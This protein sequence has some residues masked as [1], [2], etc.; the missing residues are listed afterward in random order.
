[1]AHLRAIL[2]IGL[3]SWSYALDVVKDD[4]PS[5]QAFLRQKNLTERTFDTISLHL[6]D[7]TASR[8]GNASRFSANLKKLVTSPTYA[9]GNFHALATAQEKQRGLHPDVPWNSSVLSI[10]LGHDSS[11]ALSH[12][13]RVQCVLELERL[14]N[15]RYFD[16]QIASFEHNMGYVAS[17]LQALRQFRQHCAQHGLE[18][19]GPIRI[20]FG[21]I[22][23]GGQPR[24]DTRSIAQLV[25]S[26]FEVSEWCL[27]SPFRPLLG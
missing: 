24:G 26:E 21:V 20:D 18:R 27:G 7:V 6:H 2:H 13:G 5:I 12:S 14:F 25:R 17:V 19:E 16:A 22:V 1:M 9:K 10:Y 23:L 11:F 15:V 3:V 8:L 4:F